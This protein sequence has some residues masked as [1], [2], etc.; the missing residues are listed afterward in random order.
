MNEQETE[1]LTTGEGS[2]IPELNEGLLGDAPEGHDDLFASR[3]KVLK[4]AHNFTG[5]PREIWSKISKASGSELLGGG[6]AIDCLIKLKHYYMHEADLRP[7]EKGEIKRVV[8]T[9]LFDE[10]GTGYAFVSDGIFQ[11]VAILVQTFGN[12][13]FEPPLKVMVKEIKT[14]G[15]GKILRLVSAE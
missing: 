5:S 10:N 8:R 4:T 1:S 2:I 7:D 15:K 3:G 11:D 9:V 12:A 6:K 13:P 14:G